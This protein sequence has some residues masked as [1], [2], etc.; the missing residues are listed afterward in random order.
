M[1]KTPEDMPRKILEY[2]ARHNIGQREMARRCRLTTQTISSLENGT[3]K[4]ITALTML[5]IQ[6]VLDGTYADVFDG[7]E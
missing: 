1:A 6:N 3:R 4:N 2:R 7:K 5:K